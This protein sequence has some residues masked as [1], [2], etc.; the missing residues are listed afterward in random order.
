[1]EK[2]EQRKTLEEK[3]GKNPLPQMMKD[4][5]PQ[6]PEAQSIPSRIKEK[7]T[8][9]QEYQSHSNCSTQIKRKSRRSS[10]RKQMFYLEEHQLGL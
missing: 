10:Q 8:T 4:S 2:T 1:M 5:N 9:V 7:K 6:I 3:M